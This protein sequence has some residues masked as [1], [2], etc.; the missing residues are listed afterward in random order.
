MT[1]SGNRTPDLLML[2]P[3]PSSLGHMCVSFYVVV[4]FVVVI[5]VVVVLFFF[6]FFFF[7]GGED[8][9]IYMN[10]MEMLLSCYLILCIKC[11]AVCTEDL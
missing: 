10:N 9:Y 7:W 1:S 4:V 8:L 5:V 2:S 6:F 3:T 11:C